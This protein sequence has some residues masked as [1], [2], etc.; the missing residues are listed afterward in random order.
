[1]IVPQVEN[2]YDVVDENEYAETVS[3][4]REEDWIVD[5]DGGYVEDGRE[6]F[7]D[8]E[9]D[10]GYGGAGEGNGGKTKTKEKGEKAKKEGSKSANIKNMLLSMPSKKAVDQ[11][12]LEDDEL[13]GDIL[14]SIEAKKK[15]TTGVKK[16]GK[17]APQQGTQ[18]PGDVSEAERNPFMKKGTGLKKVVKRQAVA[19]PTSAP[20]DAGEGGEASARAEVADDDMAMEGFDD[21]MDFGEEMEEEMDEEVKAESK[22]EV[23]DTGDSNR[24]FVS[25]KVEST[26]LGEG[27][28]V[29]CGAGE[30]VKEEEVKVDTSSLPTVKVEEE[31]VLRMYWLDAHE[32]PYK[33]PGTV[34]LFGKVAV[35]PRKFVSCCVTVKNIPRR[36]YLAKVSL[37]PPLKFNDF[38]LRG[39]RT[40]RPE[41]LSQ[42]WTCTTSLTQRYDI[43]HIMHKMYNFTSYRWPRD[44]RSVISNVGLWR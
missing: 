27:Q 2:V 26:S 38:H 11:G 29:S 23:N 44:T 40:A 20:Q 41:S 35:Q 31:E 1:M 32:D 15:V 12:K 28:W 33:H 39:R 14:S 21:E 17:V 7:D 10:L 16:V 13:L 37:N 34:W 36:I 9:G 3:K 19:L 8:E 5:D 43:V 18:R 4:K 42:E 25:A 30:Q 6:I 24:G 22:L